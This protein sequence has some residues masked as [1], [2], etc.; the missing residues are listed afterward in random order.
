[1]DRIIFQVLVWD[2]GLTGPFDLIAKYAFFKERG[3][4]KM[5]PLK[6]GRLP[7]TGAENIIF[8]T[9]P[10]ITNMDFIADNVKG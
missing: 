9:R 5:F 2:E 7:Q 6:A 8:L 10:E 4:I 3:V 1:M